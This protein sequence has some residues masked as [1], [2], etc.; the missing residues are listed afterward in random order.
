MGSRSLLRDNDLNGF[1]EGLALSDMSRPT[2]L[3][4]DQAARVPFP[5]FP[6]K[7]VLKVLTGL[8]AIVMDVRWH[9]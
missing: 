1:A 2:D 8:F 4:R 6:F 3:G 7:R 9:T 5:S